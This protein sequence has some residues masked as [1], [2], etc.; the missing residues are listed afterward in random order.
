MSE[1]QIR[2]ACMEMA[3]G[4]T[5]PREVPQDRAAAFVLWAGG[6]E[7]RLACVR[8]A[9]KSHGHLA[10]I[11][12]GRLL[13]EAQKYLDF[14]TPPAPPEVATRRRGRSRRI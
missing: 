8:L 2:L 3:I 6:D 14:V 13:E 1:E 5:G 12:A 7:T 9:V 11:G 4:G 10:R